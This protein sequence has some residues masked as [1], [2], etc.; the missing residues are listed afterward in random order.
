MYAVGIG[1]VAWVLLKYIP[2][3]NY[4][5]EGNV[6]A[7][8]KAKEKALIVGIATEEQIERE[9]QKEKQATIGTTG[10]EITEPKV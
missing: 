5:S 2:D 6:I 1:C 4:F 3:T 10:E 9:R 8:E 7:P